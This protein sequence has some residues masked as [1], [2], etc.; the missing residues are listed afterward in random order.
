ME[1]TITQ[2]QQ[3]DSV[4]IWSPKE[5][6]EHWQGHRRL[7]RRMIEAFPEDELFSYSI[8]G[9]RPFAKMVDEFLGMASPGMQGIATGKWVTPDQI[10]Y[11]TGLAGATTKAELL[12]KWDEVTDEINKLWANLPAS[13][14]REVE[15]AFGTWEGPIYG[16]ILYWIENE[17]HHRG[18][19]YVYLRSLGIDPP[20]FWER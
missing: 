17:V 9:M 12:S 10:P 20:P 15:A 5:L 7:T 19:A 8:G 13:R 14:F 3:S 4:C 18:Q 6:L 1:K 2:T 16:T 11:H